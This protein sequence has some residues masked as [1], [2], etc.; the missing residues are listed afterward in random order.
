MKKNIPSYK[1]KS[2][3]FRIPKNKNIP[4]TP[5]RCLNFTFFVECLFNFDYLRGTVR[6]SWEMAPF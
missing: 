3:F 4:N 2:V 5:P 6:E 1:K